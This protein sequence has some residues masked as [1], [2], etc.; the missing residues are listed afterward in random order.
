[1]KETEFD[2]ELKKAISATHRKELKEDLRALEASIS[3]SKSR[4][5]K[6]NWRIAAS[7]AIFVG[8]GSLLFLFNQDPS[9]EELYNS[10]FS[11]YE[12]VV[13]PIVRDQV[14]RSKKAQAFADYEQ[15]LYQKAVEG[16]N[17]LTPNDSLDVLTLQFYKANALLKLEQ[18]EKAK[19]LFE[20]VIHQNQK[21]KEE[22]HWYL[23]LILLK[24]NDIESSLS[25]LKK[26]QETDSIFKSKE[27]KHLLDKLN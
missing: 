23:A 10:Y 3:E 14:N 9:S 13:A 17:G 2:N 12:N 24:L 20:Q 22:S 6:F 19:S 7:V 16:L 18:F 26:L 4:A 11:P 1:M 21:W 25:Q 8:L 27:I 15:G 5:P